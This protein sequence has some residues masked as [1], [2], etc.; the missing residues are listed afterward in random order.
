MAGY[1]TVIALAGELDQSGHVSLLK[2][3][4]EEEKATDAKLSKLA[5]VVN[6]EAIQ[7]TA[8]DEEKQGS[9]KKSRSAA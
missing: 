9:P 4:L 3:T 8:Q 7:D 2:E 6:A 5:S 1:G